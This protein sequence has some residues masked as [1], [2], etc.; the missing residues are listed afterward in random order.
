ML[1]YK[2]LLIWKERGFCLREGG[3]IWGWSSLVQRNAHGSKNSQNQIRPLNF[4]PSTLACVTGGQLIYNLSLNKALVCSFFYFSVIW[5]LLFDHW[6]P[7]TLPKTNP[8][9]PIVYFVNVLC[10]SSS[11]EII[12]N[13]IIHHVPVS[14]SILCLPQSPA[15]SAVC[16]SRG[17][18]ASGED[19]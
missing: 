1:D 18:N 6:W 15:A 9:P 16:S 3:V 13:E 8:P 11:V 12:L 19:L 10:Y 5:R 14:L 2:G 17:R 7:S 4:H